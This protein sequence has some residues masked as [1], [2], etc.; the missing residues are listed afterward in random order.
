MSSDIAE[1]KATNFMSL[2]HP[3]YKLVSLCSLIC[4]IFSSETT[5]GSL[6]YT[7]PAEKVRW[8]FLKC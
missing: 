6:P 8:L 4:V 7:G 5:M 2:D 3:V 1:Q